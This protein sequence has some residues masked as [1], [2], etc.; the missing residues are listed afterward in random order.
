MGRHNGCFL[1]KNIR[2]N[3]FFAKLLHKNLHNSKIC[4]TFA[5]AFE[6]HGGL[7]SVGRASDC[8]SECRGEAKPKTL[9]RSNLT[10]YGGF[11]VKV[12]RKCPEN[13]IKKFG[14]KNEQKH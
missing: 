6:Q 13:L 7:S 10:G 11:S 2:I 14:Q 4:S 1:E 8:G 12:S 3:A 9:I 5:P